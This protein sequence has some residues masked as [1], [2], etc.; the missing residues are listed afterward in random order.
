MTTGTKTDW[1]GS[2]HQ[3][4]RIL[5]PADYLEPYLSSEGLSPSEVLARLPFDRA[6]TNDPNKTMPDDKRRR[7]VRHMCE[8]TGLAYEDDD[9]L[10]RVTEL[11]KA[12]LRWIRSEGGRPPLINERNALILGEHAAY[13]LAA[14]QLR[15]PT[16]AG[17][18][19][20][21]SMI[22]FPFAFIW[23]VML[24]LDCR[25]TS[26]ELNRAVLRVC[27]ESDIPDCIQ[28]IADARA[29]GDPSLMGEETLTNK[30]KNDRLIAWIALASF[31]WVLIQDKR[32]TGGPFYQI[33]PGA[34]DILRSALS[35]PHEH[36]VFE[37]KAEYVRYIS[38]KALLPGDFR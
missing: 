9:D 2:L 4:L 6:R 36:R 5:P 22:V 16:G 11:G 20:H 1:E 13:A 30:K 7:D 10:L 19:Y 17:I 21:S 37:T 26:D 33:R 24:A 32:E 35:V 28:R 31:G 27:D 23:R 34:E 38:D 8:W 15:N 25:I 3:S 14:C 29:A 18:K 12:V